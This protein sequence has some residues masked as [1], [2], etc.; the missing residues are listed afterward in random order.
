[1]I[2]EITIKISFAEAP[3]AGGATAVLAGFGG[4]EIAPPTLDGGDAAAAVIPSPPDAEAEFA[5]A[6]GLDVPPSPAAEAAQDEHLPPPGAEDRP[7]DA[8]DE[9]AAPPSHGKGAKRGR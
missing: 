5:A 3:G 4:A 1:M 7:G 8:S 6:A 9:D 2:P